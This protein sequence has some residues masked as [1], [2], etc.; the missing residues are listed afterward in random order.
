MKYESIATSSSDE[1]SIAQLMKSVKDALVKHGDMETWILADVLCS[2]IA[3]IDEAS[4]IESYVFEDGS[5]LT[6]TC[7]ALDDYDESEI[8]SYDLPFEDEEE[9]QR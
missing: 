9:E 5:K 3:T 2:R 1:L 4:T 6:E 7:C 8:L